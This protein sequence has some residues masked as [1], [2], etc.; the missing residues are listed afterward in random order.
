MA[1]ALKE[2][3]NDL[4]KAGRHAEAVKKYDEA[5][6]ALKGLTDDDAK[7]TTTKCRLNKVA[8]LL[9]LQGYAAAAHECRNVIQAE[10]ENAKALFR[11]G[12]AAELLGDYGTAQRALTDSI[13]LQPSLKEPRDLLA[14]IQARLKAN[15]RLEQ[16][17]QDMSLIEERGLRALNYADLKAARQQLELLLKD[18]RAH[19]EAHWEARALLA[20]ALLCEDDGETEAATDYIDAARRKLTA[21]DDRRAELYCLQTHAIVFIDRGYFKEALPLLEGGLMLAQEMGEKGLSAR[22]LCN[23]ALVHT[24]SGEYARGVEDGTLAVSSARERNDRHFEAVAGSVLAQALRKSRMYESAYDVLEN[25]TRHAEAIGYAHVLGATLREAAFLAL[26]DTRGSGGGGG[27]G[28]EEEGDGE[29][30]KVATRVKKALSLL[31][32]CHKISTANGLRRAACDDALNLYTTRLKYNNVIGG[33]KEARER[34]LKGLAGAIKEATSIQY[35]RCRLDLLLAIS[36][37]YMRDSMNESG[38]TSAASDLEEAEGY[39]ESAVKLVEKGS[40]AE[41]TKYVEI[42]AMIYTNKCLCH[43]LRV[44]VGTGKETPDLEEWHRDDQ[45]LNAL[46]C[47]EQCLCVATGQEDPIV[48]AARA[49]DAAGL[50]NLGVAM[51]AAGRHSSEQHEADVP[52]AKAKAKGLLERVLG[53]E[54]VVR[55]VQ[56]R[57][58]TALAATV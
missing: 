2:Q 35:K 56:E 43:L 31:D 36:L 1:T 46:R 42:H 6:Q 26:E 18:S 51:L 4:Y 22:F 7:D 40:D 55:E 53:L 39:L 14:Q 10:P 27:E 58:K 3:G 29:A 12:Q 28:L 52:A 44:S 9:K 41:K 17:L 32:R 34:D 21:A 16:A 20:L 47:A 15:P 8:C 45:A 57:A 49:T 50:V 38:W 54:G 24:L 23:L 13:K 48:A 11:L 19:K 25:A 37:G 30:A 5:L 33:G